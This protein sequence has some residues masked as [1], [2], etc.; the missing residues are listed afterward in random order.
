[1]ETDSQ[2]I[3][4][5]KPG[6][7]ST[8]NAE[9]M[10]Q[11]AQQAAAY[12]Q[13]RIAPANSS[14][15]SDPR[16]STNPMDSSIDALRAGVT[17]VSSDTFSRAKM[18]EGFHN[19][20]SSYNEKTGS[21]RQMAE[22]QRVNLSQNNTN[23]PKPKMTVENSLSHATHF[24]RSN[25]NSEMDSFENDYQSSTG[26]NIRRDYGSTSSLDI[27]STSSDGF[28]A[29]IDEFRTEHSDQNRD[30][31]SLAP[32]K[33]QELLRG[34][35][36]VNGEKNNNKKG[37]LNQERLK[38]TNGLVVMDKENHELV[39]KSPKLKTKFKSKDRKVRAK[40]ITGESNTGLFKKLRGAKDSDV[41]N[42]S[43]DAS[44]DGDS[45]KTDERLKQKAFIHYDC[46]S[47]GVSLNNVILRNN[48]SSARRN[49]S[50]GA[51]AASANR[52]SLVIDKEDPDLLADTDYG[53]DREN[54]LVSRCQ[55]FRN[56]IGGEEQRTIGL[57]LSTA[58]KHSQ[59]LQSHTHHPL[60]HGAI[61]LHR[62]P[63]CCGISVLDS[64]ETPIGERIPPLVKYKGNIV[65]YVDH[66][67]L[68]YRNFFAQQGES[69]MQWMLL[70]N[71]ILR[72]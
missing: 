44:L 18:T 35:Y 63:V 53:V 55:Y 22:R 20:R 13:K 7:P 14:I 10:R 61:V 25:S 9:I 68:Y 6:M 24:Y 11:R 49:T 48:S 54:S 46:Q 5:G 19:M 67:A 15:R 65:E 59:V 56:E 52:D 72:R 21:G 12:Y 45:G 38:R 16:L 23:S 17:P 60:T 8:L 66:G 4:H 70:S 71:T 33:L 30:Q 28:F 64:S 57:T 36:K 41:N 3:S 32:P 40:S 2:L 34:D 31:R 47:I 1:M 43:N 26:S 62:N 69:R 29:M 39:Q 42:K 37:L 50:T 51:S 27:L 58:Q